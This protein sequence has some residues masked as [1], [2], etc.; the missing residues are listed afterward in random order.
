MV[1]T[2]SGDSNFDSSKPM[3][4]DRYLS[5]AQTITSGGEITLVHGLVDRDGNPVKPFHVSG[6]LK[7]LVAEHGRSVGDEIEANL[8][9][10]ST[11]S[12][13]IFNQVESDSTSITIKLSNF[14]SPFLSNNKVTGA[15]VALTNANWELYIRAWA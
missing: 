8:G 13:S 3:I 5:P 10:N 14:S 12:T 15:Q 6:Y 4:D 7:C 9:D 11:G 1:A 2:V